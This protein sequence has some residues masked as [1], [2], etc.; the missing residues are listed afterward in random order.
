MPLSL[1]IEDL[2]LAPPDKDSFPHLPGEAVP[3]AG[4][5]LGL[6]HGLFSSV[7]ILLMLEHERGHLA[8]SVP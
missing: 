7:C 4:S 3:G 8:S 6:V 1:G 5:D 2:D